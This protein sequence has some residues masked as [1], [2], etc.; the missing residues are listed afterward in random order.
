MTV[1]TDLPKDHALR[2]ALDQYKTRFEESFEELLDGIA[3]VE[4]C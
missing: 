4:S 1:A 2:K 3:F